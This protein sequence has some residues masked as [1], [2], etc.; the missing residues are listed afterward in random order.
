MVYDTGSDWLAVEGS[1]CDSCEGDKFDGY[2]S[3]RST[4]SEESERNY[5]SVSLTGHTY[6]D[7]VCVTTDICVKSFEY[8]LI[9]SQVGVNGYQGLTEPVDGILGMSRDRSPPGA[10]YEVGPLYVKALRDIYVT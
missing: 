1:T 9:E 2:R 8:F 7:L 10:D 3:G 5:G 6:E 4:S